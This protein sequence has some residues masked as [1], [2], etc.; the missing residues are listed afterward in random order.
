MKSYFLPLGSGYWK[1]Y[2]S[3]WDSFWCCTGSGAE[4]FAKFA[5]TIYFHDDQGVYVNLFIASELNWPEKGP[6]TVA[7]RLLP[8]AATAPAS[9]CPATSSSRSL[10]A[11]MDA[12]LAGSTAYRARPSAGEGDPDHALH[13]GGQQPSD[14]ASSTS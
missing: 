14:L 6:P 2:N 13:G 7:V 8:A 9:T 1:Y 12:W 11:W 3:A 4:E 5:D 10:R